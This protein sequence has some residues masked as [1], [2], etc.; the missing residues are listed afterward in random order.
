[1][2]LVSDGED[3]CAPP[4]PCQVASELKAAGVDLVVHTIGFKVE[5]KARSEL[6]CVAAATGGS[7][8]EASSGADLARAL[9]SR[10]QRAIRPYAAV[11]APVRGGAT[12]A[13]A[14]T[15]GPGQY[16]DT[17]ERGAARG[18][19]EGTVK[20]YAV[21]LRPG[22]T[23]WFSATLA[24]PAVRVEFLDVLAVRLNLVDAAGQDCVPSSAASIDLGVF[25]KVVAQTALV[26]SGPVGD[27]RWNASCKAGASS[28]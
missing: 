25:G 22:D 8:R 23:P 10:V 2:V 20:F 1:V 28:T 27:R 14:P 7:Y 4:E 16:L 13:D 19:G 17:Y 12:P 18:S 6:S 15:V 3:T 26:E 21:E 24:P 11:G 5:A 9:T